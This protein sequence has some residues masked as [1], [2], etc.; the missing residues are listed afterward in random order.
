MV[1]SSKEKLTEKEF[2]LG[3]MEKSTMENGI[4]V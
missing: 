3:L 4:K 1:I 2:T